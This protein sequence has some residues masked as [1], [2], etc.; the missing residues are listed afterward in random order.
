MNNISLNHFFISFS[1]KDKDDPGGIDDVNAIFDY[2]EEIGYNFIYDS[3]M[4]IG[5]EW[6]TRARRYISSSKCLGVAVLLSKRSLVSKPVLRELDLTRLNNKPVMP[7]VVGADSLDELYSKT[8]KFLTSEEDLFVVDE[9]MK[10]FNPE[11]IFIT[12]K[13]F[14]MIRTFFG[15]KSK[16]NDVPEQGLLFE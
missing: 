9:I 16:T 5:S 7:I 4:S 8:V 3:E 2:F 10:F 14:G 11:T 13:Q 15:G 1:H 12:D 6:D